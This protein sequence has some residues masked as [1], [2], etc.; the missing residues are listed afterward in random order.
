MELIIKTEQGFIQ[1]LP[2]D[3]YKI[4]LNGD[5]TQSFTEVDIPLGNKAEVKKYIAVPLD[6]PDETVEI[7]P[8]TPTEDEEISDSEA[9]SIITGGVSDE[10]V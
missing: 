5:N 10:T 7:F 4:R 8:I 3:G 6:E 9:L 2:P 1:V